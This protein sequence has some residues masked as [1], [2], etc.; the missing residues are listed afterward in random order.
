MQN[1]CHRHTFVDEAM[2]KAYSFA[3]WGNVELQATLC[4][5]DYTSL[6]KALENFTSQFSSHN[7]Q[8]FLVFF[9]AF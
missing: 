4:V 7:I 2:I 3:N 6:T 8:S 1:I 9:Q 5:T